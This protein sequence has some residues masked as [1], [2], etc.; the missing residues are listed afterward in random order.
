[1]ITP[2]LFARTGPKLADSLLSQ[3]ENIL[4]QIIEVEN[5][6]AAEKK[7]FVGYSLGGRLGLHILQ[8]QPE[9]FDRYIFLSTHPGLAE[10][11]VEARALRKSSDEK[12]IAMLT[13]N[14][15]KNFLFQ[16]NA[17]GVFADS[18]VEPECSLDE[19]D[20]C[21]LHQ[22]LKGWSLAAQADMRSVIQ[23]NKDKI[24]WVVGRKDSKYLQLAEELKQAEVI[25]AYDI[26]DG[27]HRLHL[28]ST[29]QLC[30]LLKPG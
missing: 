27:G 25:N 21:K 10:D 18:L 11:D 12:W 7:I 15:W 8:R 24:Y 4:G 28:E 1:M 2:S 13:E 23:K 14:N 30:K 26:F 6:K 9:V 29:T 5:Q 16:W 20:L 22:A 3:A 19:Y 17:Q